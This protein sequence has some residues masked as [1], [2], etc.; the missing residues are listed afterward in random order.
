M[1]LYVCDE[2]DTIENTACG[3]FWSKDCDDTPA[4]VKGRALCSACGPTH[5]ND[6]SRTKYGQWHGRF[7]RRKAT[8][9]IIAENPD[10]YIYKGRFAP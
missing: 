7:E 3:F 5:W 4:T 10:W 2:C 6:G 8:A 9:E 1:P